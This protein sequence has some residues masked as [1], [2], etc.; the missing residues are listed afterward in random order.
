MTNNNNSKKISLALC[1]FVNTPLWDLI[2]STKIGH[3]LLQQNTIK[4]DTGVWRNLA[5]IETVKKVTEW[6]MKLNYLIRT[7]SLTS[8][9]KKYCIKILNYYE[10]LLYYRQNI[11]HHKVDTLM[12]FVSLWTLPWSLYPYFFPSFKFI[13]ET[14]LSCFG[15]FNPWGQLFWA[16]PH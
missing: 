9:K 7:W 3:V 16:Y 13:S 15:G 11:L 8:R 14:W 2:W 5:K 10:T 6:D 12:L 4:S 1:Y